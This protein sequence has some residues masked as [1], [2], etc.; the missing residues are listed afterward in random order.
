MVPLLLIQP[1]ISHAVNVKKLVPTAWAFNVLIL[2]SQELDVV[3]TRELHSL[4]LRLLE[5]LAIE[6]LLNS[7]DVGWVVS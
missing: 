3:P 4:E 6:L 2:G 1:L 7:M 5:L